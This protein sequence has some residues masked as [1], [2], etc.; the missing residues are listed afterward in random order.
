[1]Y[2]NKTQIHAPLVQTKQ[3]KT[4]KDNKTKS[5]IKTNKPAHKLLSASHCFT[6]LQY[7]TNT[8]RRNPDFPSELLKK[9]FKNYF[10]QD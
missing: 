8:E 2:L 4:Y 9:L 7:Y 10:Y 3:I 5:H 1:M 6:C